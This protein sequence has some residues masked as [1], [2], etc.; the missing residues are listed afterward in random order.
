MKPKS[1][2]L[3]ILL[4]VLIGCNSPSG[5]E[6]TT[7]VS[8]ETASET[9]TK[10]ISDLDYRQIV[11]MVL[12]DTSDLSEWHGTPIEA[13]A[14]DDLTL[15]MEG[16]CGENDCG[17][18]VFLTNNGQRAISATIS[19]VYAVEETPWLLSQVVKVNPGDKVSLGCSHLCYGEESVLFERKIEGS[20]YSD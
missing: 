7:E 1:T 5:K 11:A 3:S 12:A 10:S 4:M 8:T 2:T 9:T 16:A 6:S 20:N 14:N 19:A 17:R 15:S 13:V 18:E